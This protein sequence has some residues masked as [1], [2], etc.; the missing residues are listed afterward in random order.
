MSLYRSRIFL[1]SPKGVSSEH[2]NESVPLREVG[3]DEQVLRVLGP[4]LLFLERDLSASD[5]DAIVFLC[6]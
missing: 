2:P 6:Q 5:I 1:L 3:G 4:P